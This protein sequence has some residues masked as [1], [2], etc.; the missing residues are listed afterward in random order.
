MK[1][2]QHKQGVQG[3]PERIYL[4]GPEVFLQN[5]REIG[6]L[7]KALCTKIRIR[8]RVP[9][10]LRIDTHNKNRYATGLL[11]SAAN[12]KLI[13]SCRYVIANI[14]PFRGPSADAGTVYEI[15]CARGC[16]LKI[17]AYSN[18]TLSYTERVCR[19]FKTAD[20]LDGSD[21]LRDPHAMA[22]EDYAMADNLM[23]E[24]G[25]VSSGGR[26]VLNDVPVSELFTSLQGCEQCLRYLQTSLQ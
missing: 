23:I 22:I 26:L 12:E 21:Q 24:G 18:T 7:K 19:F 14:T 25:I 15:G 11:I 2:T 5:A 9:P 4:A 10:G 8:G 3:Q 20:Q 13:K 16:G 17:F 1:N 6:E